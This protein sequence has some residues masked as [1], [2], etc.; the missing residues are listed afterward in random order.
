MGWGRGWPPACSLVP[1]E[2]AMRKEAFH[3]RADRDY[4]RHLLR[5]GRAVDVERDGL[6]DSPSG[7]ISIWCSRDDRPACRDGTEIQ[8]FYRNPC[9]PPPRMCAPG[10]VGGNDLSWHAVRP[11]GFLSRKTQ[12]RTPGLSNWR[13]VL[14]EASWC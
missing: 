8:P 2:A 11:S 5:A 9:L 14:V 7:V 4:P 3:V 13:R 1:L 12:A 10:M 6:Y